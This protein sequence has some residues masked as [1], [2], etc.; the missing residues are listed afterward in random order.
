M[1]LASH[2]IS[3]DPSMCGLESDSPDF[4]CTPLNEREAAVDRLVRQI[5][6]DLPRD[7]SPDLY[8]SLLAIHSGQIAQSRST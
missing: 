8:A 6:Q 5:E 1:T 2:G 3:N 4:A 7:H